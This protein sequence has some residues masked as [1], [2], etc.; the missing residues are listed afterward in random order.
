MNNILEN[1]YNSKNLNLKNDLDL[2]VSA[3][4]TDFKKV[5]QSAINSGIDYAIKSLDCN[6]ELKESLNEI[7]KSFK[8]KNSKEILDTAIDSSIKFGME[9]AKQKFPILKTLDGIKAVT[10][11]GGIGTLLS[12]AIDIISSKYLKGNLIGDTLNKFFDNLKGFVK[13][14]AFI[15]KLEQGINKIKQQVNDFKGMCTNW[16]KAYEN[17]DMKN[18]NDIAKS[19]KSFSTKI[20]NNPE[21]L[22]EGNTIQNMTEL[23]NKKMDKLSQ[24]QI[25]ICANI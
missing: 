22:R 9:F 8:T 17:F 10:L 18:I 23:I 21:C 5:A 24:T 16:Y 3:S 2:N 25:E 1:I 20:V 15:Q 7:K 14:N 13:S 19:I 11:K 12:S 6:S 4:L